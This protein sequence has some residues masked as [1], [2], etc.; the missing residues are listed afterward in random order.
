M[1]SKTVEVKPAREVD[2]AILVDI[3]NT[4]RA[5]V[6]CYSEVAFD[7]E[8]FLAAIDGEEVHVGVLNG[9]VAGF[10][11]VWAAD[12]FIHH[13]YVL[14]QYQGFGVGSRLLHECAEIYGLPLSVKCDLCNENA[15]RFYR[16]KGWLPSERGVGPDGF[17][18]RFE[19]PSA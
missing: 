10:A 16:G 6:G 18:E 7:T 2:L 1:R 5:G 17:W 19:S 15:G 9:T 8:R 13:L 3:F 12:R 14:P 4:S 11:S